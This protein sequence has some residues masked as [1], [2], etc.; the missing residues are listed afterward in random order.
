[1]FIFFF[2]LP[3]FFWIWSDLIWFLPSFFFFFC[4]G[5]FDGSEDVSDWRILHSQ[6]PS[7]RQRA[8]R[9]RWIN[10]KDGKKILKCDNADKSEGLRRKT[11]GKIKSNEKESKCFSRK[12]N[13]FEW[14]ACY[15][16]PAA[17]CCLWPSFSRSFPLSYLFPRLSF[18]RSLG[19]P[20]LQH[21]LM[22][23]SVLIL[24]QVTL[25]AKHLKAEVD[26]CGKHHI[27]SI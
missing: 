27:A 23:C 15:C 22:T 4:W 11:K 5:F 21:C 2:L 10:Q 18:W 17:V 1:M 9:E 16:D 6:L 24:I 8:R 25:L 3:M 19:Y 12:W 14:F 7:K 13:T 26:S 20:D